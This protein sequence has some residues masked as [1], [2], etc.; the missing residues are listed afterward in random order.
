MT[1]TE[2]WMLLKAGADTL[3]RQRLGDMHQHVTE[4]VMVFHNDAAQQIAELRAPAESGLGAELFKALT[5]VLMVA[6][7]EELIIEKVAGEAIKAFRD[8]MVAGIHEAGQQAT[9]ATYE[10]AHDQLAHILNDLVAATQA[11]ATQAWHSAAALVP[12]S[13]DAF[14]DAHPDYKH[15]E[16]GADAAQWEAWICDQIGIRDAAV[17]NPA[18]TMT[19]ALWHAFHTDY[20]RISAQV[21]WHDKNVLEQVEFLHDMDPAQRDPFLHMMGARDLENW[22]HALALWETNQ[23]AAAQQIPFLGL[24]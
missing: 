21:R 14:F 20:Y 11:S 18:A 7:P 2:P 15:H 19:E 5:G 9:A 1:Q 3:A 23:V 12:Q 6:F 8:V 24:E 13:L 4:T 16:F 10:Q 22:H 17:A